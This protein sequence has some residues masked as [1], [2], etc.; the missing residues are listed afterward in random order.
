[1]YRGYPVGYLLFWQNALSEGVR[2]IGLDKKQRTPDLL[3]VD[4]QQRLTSLYAVVKRIPVVR[5]NKQKELIKIAFNPLQE[6]LRSPTRLSSETN[7]IS[8]IYP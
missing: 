1:M 2:T 6:N 5:A 7:R 4:G 8:R 3:I